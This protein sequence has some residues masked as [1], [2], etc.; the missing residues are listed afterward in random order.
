MPV[1]ISQC[2]RQYA[3]EKNLCVLYNVHIC[4]SMAKCE[5]LSKILCIRLLFSSASNQNFALFLFNSITF[6][7]KSSLP[8][9]PDPPC[10]FV[11]KITI[12][13]CVNRGNWGRLG[14]FSNILCLLLKY[15]TQVFKSLHTDHQCC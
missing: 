11:D 9:F 8:S 12:N 13:M 10:S 7:P 1:K 2:I 15:F 5:V 14:H 3:F 4:A 6:S